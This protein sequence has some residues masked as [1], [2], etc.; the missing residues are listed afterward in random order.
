ML[1]WKK[2]KFCWTNLH[3]IVC[4]TQY[5]DTQQTIHNTINNTQHKI[6][7]CY[8]IS[9]E[10]FVGLVK[11]VFGEMVCSIWIGLGTGGSWSLLTATDDVCWQR[12][13]MFVDSNRWSVSWQMTVWFWNDDSYCEI[14]EQRPMD[15][16]YYRVGGRI[17]RTRC[18]APSARFAAGRA[19]S[20]PDPTSTCSRLWKAS[21][22]SALYTVSVWNRLKQG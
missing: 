6:H 11:A 13:M 12:Q 10:T 7:S 4:T 2:I 21:V 20:T 19:S 22:H 15:I 1:L 3:L 9:F 14:C 16:C 18:L 8:I 5:C 17:P